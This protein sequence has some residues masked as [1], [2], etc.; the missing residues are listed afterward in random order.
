MFPSVFLNPPV[1]HSFFA[2]RILRRHLSWEEE[3][4]EEEADEDDAD[5]CFFP[6]FWQVDAK[7]RGGEAFEVKSELV[8]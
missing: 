8:S 3:D 2:L 7:K 4:A 5:L 1:R 6:F